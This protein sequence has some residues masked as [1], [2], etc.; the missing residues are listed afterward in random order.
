[1]NKKNSKNILIVG[2]SLYGCILA[3]QLSKNKKNNIYIID[4]S[5]RVL[6]SLNSIKINEY[7]INNGFHGIE[8]PRALKLLNFL[9]DNLKLKFET[10]N[11]IHKI[12]INRNIIDFKDGYSEWPKTIQNDLKN[13]YLIHT[14]DKI[15]KFYSKNM[16]KL[17]S[18]C[19]KRYNKNINEYKHLIMPWFL[20]KEYKIISN[21]E[22][23]IFR[24]KVR[25]KKI[26]FKYAIPKKKLFKVFQKSF[27]VFLKKKG[28]KIKLNTSINF[29]KKNF[30]VIENRKKIFC[31][32][33]FFNRIYFCAPLAFLLRSINYKHFLG[34]NKYKRYFINALFRVEKKMDFTEMICL[35]KKFKSLS[36]I[37]ILKNKKN[38]LQIELIRDQEKFD[39]KENEK[40]KLEL[41]K[42]F[43]FKSD[44]ILLGFKTSRL[45]FWPSK[46]W[47]TK[48]V[49]IIKGWKKN[50]NSKINIRYSFGPINM[51]KAWIYSIEDSK[52]INKSIND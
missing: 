17:V 14:K 33:N 1:M 30:T 7:E 46:K 28:V 36:R 6:S 49:D 32:K 41:K 4:Q 42:I 34:L 16:L 43:K 11:K 27:L 40:L 52:K 23:D 12:L 5:S 21:D 15:S 31:E 13:N 25:D 29:D 47:N 9:K 51:A 44:P 48:A 24:Q 26:D 39:F 20:P 3:Y 2:T 50:F 37:S 19:S 38:I 45:M 8:I 10:Y 22:G 35:N 18:F